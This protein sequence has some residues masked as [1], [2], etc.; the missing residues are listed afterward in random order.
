MLECTCSNGATVG[1]RR[2]GENS[3]HYLGR[4][5]HVE[6]SDANWPLNKQCLSFSPFPPPFT[7]VAVCGL[8]IF[9]RCNFGFMGCLRTSGWHGNVIHNLSYCNMVLCIV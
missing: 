1:P 7:P 5:W 2:R 3:V 8:V 9:V 6:V 4:W